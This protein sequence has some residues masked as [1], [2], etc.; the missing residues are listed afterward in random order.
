MELRELD[1]NLLLVFQEVFRERQIS[2]A[3]RRL[4]LTQSAVSN[5]LARLRRAT[6]D[7]LFVRTAAG[8]QPTPYAEHMAEPVATALSHLEQALA[9]A[10]AF[11]PAASRRRFTVAMTDVGEVYFMPR[12]VELCGA[13]APGVGIASVRAGTADLRGEMEAGR[14]DLAIGAFDDAPGALYQRRLFRQEYVTLLRA[15]HPLATGA[16]TM[17]R[18]AAARHLVVAA[19]ESPYDRINTALQK[20]GILTSA[21]FSV[22]HFSAAPYIVGTTDLVVTV[23][24]KLAERAAAPFGLVYVKSPLRLAALQTNVFWHRRYNQDEGNRWLRTLVADAFA[25]PATA[26]DPR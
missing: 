2:A 8:M 23:P 15:G 12:L 9:P 11:D 3:A 13:A 17:K 1:L 25:E 21:S 16:L 26:T 24:Q 7:E 18:F 6:G 10:Q 22:P 14:I 4:R 20:A 5:A 19:L